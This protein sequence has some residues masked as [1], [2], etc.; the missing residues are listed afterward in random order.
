MH[1]KNIKIM[2]VKQLKKNFPNW[3]RL[4]RKKKKTLARQVL[5][6]TYD[7]YPFDQNITVPL[8]ELTGTPAIGDAKIMTLD[9]MKRFIADNKSNIIPFLAPS[10]KKQLAD[11]ELKA[12][13]KLLDNTII[14]KLLAQK[15]YTPSMHKIF[16][17]HLLRA[18]LLKSLKHPELS[19]RKYCPAQVNKLEQKTNRAFVGL[20]LHKKLS[21]DHSQ[22]CQFRI[23]LKFS[24]MVNLMV[25]VIYLFEESGKLASCFVVH[26]TDSTELPA[27]SNSMPLA[28]I[29]VKDKKVRIY[30]DLDA[31]CGKRR[32]KRDKSEYFVGYRMHTIAAINP[33]TGQSY[34]LISLIAPG[35][36]HDSLFLKQLV[37]LGKAIGLDLRLITADEAYGDA[38]QNHQIQ[39]EHNVT[40]IAPPSKKV[41]TPEH[42]DKDTKAVYMN[43]WCEVPMQYLGKTDEGEHEF[44]CDAPKEECIHSSTCDKYRQI[45]LDAGMFGQIPAQLA[46]VKEVED[47]RKHIERPFNLLKHREGLEPLRVRSQQGLMAVAAFANMA[48]LLLEIVGTRKTKIKENRY[49]QL[50]L[51]LAA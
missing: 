11:R 20:P 2:V 24:Q 41:K 7:T 1:E 25:Y 12:I 22:L 33:Q 16:P 43:K 44:G 3:K 10:R 27:V 36:H 6:E 28:T 13:D 4:N 47:L 38:E 19:Y 9:A 35:N 31:D 50:E 29:K 34:P 45:A 21:I 32:K 26:G 14:D 30:A 48:N 42:V 8:H 51:E 40:V 49:T 5:K 18:E 17:H 23:G 37:Q 39:Q 15:G 46:G